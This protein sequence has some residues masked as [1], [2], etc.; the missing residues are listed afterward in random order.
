MKKLLFSFLAGFFVFGLAIWAPTVE[1]QQQQKS[2]EEIL[3]GKWHQKADQK[4]QRQREQLQHDPP[5]TKLGV[6]DQREIRRR[7][8]QIEK[9]RQQD[10]KDADD[11]IKRLGPQK[12]QPPKKQ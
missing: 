8:A 4:A 5:R 10:R 6:V 7:E 2:K 12:S 1:A 11:A 9:Q 3:R